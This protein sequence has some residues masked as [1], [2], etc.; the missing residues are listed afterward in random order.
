MCKNLIFLMSF[1]VVL[2]L[3]GGAWAYDPG[4]ILQCDAGDDPPTDDSPLQAGWT[5]IEDGWNVDVNSTGISVKLATG[6]PTAIE[7]RD[8]DDLSGAGHLADVEIDLFFANDR[9]TSPE[10]DFI[11][12]LTGLQNGAYRVRSYHNRWDEPPVPIT[13]VTVTGADS[14]LS[15]PSQWYWQEHLS[16]TIPL[17]VLFT[18]TGGQVEIR[19]KGPDFG[20]GG[21]GQVYFNGFTLEYFG[22]QNEAAYNPSPGDQAQ[23]LCPGDVASLSW[24]AGASASTHDIYFS[25]DIND[26]DPNESPTP[27]ESGWASTSWTPPALDLGTTY[28]WRVD[29]DT[30]STTWEGAIWR[31]TTNNGS[32]YDPYPGDGWRGV[33]TD[34]N[35]SWSPGCEADSH[36]VYFST[37]FN[38]VNN[39][40]P[41]GFKVNQTEL[42]YDP[43]ALTANTTYYW[44]I[45]EVRAGPNSPGEVW[46]FK[47]GT[48]VSGAIMYFKFDD[49]PLGTDLPS[50]V[51]DSTGNETF[52][53]FILD[54]NDPND[55][56]KYGVSNP[57]VNAA[58]GFS[59]EFSP[60]AGLYRNGQGSGD[61]LAL[62]GYQYTVEVWFNA[63]EVPGS[64]DDD[65]RGEGDKLIARGSSFWTLE[66]SRRAGLI[67][68]HTGSEG[69]RQSKFIYSGKNTVQEGEWYHAAAV[70]DITDSDQAMKLYLDGQLMATAARPQANP[71]DN[72][73]P[74]AIGF[75]RGDND[76]HFDGLIDEVRISNVALTVDE[77]LLVPGP[78]WARSPYPANN[79]RRVDPNVV[80]NWVPG[81]GAGTHDVYLGTSYD[82]IVGATTADT[83]LFL[84]NVGP[85]SIDPLGPDPLSFGTR[86][87][88]RVDE[89]N[90]GGPYTGVVWSFT[91]ASEVDDPNMI[92]WYMFDE[93]SGDEAFDASGH[94]YF[95]SV[96]GDEDGWDPN[97]GEGGC[98]IFDNDTAVVIPTEMLGNIV[99]EISIAVWL[100]DADKPGDDNWLFD[101][102]GGAP[103]SMSIAV[104]DEDGN[105]YWRAGTDGEDVLI[106]N[107]RQA[108][109][110]PGTLEDWHHWVFIKNENTPEISIYFDGELADTNGIVDS[111]LGYLRDLPSRV[112][113]YGDN[114]NDLVGKVDDFMVFD[115]AL[116]DDKVQELF[117]RGDVAL[118]WKPNPLNGQQ[119][120]YWDADLTWKPG[121]YT[122]STGGH[123]VYFGADWDD[124]NDMTDPCATLNLGNELYDPGQL[125]L[126]KTY[127]WR[128][129]EVNEPTTYKGK[130]WSFTVA[131][132]VV[133][134]DFESYDKGANLIYYTWY[135]KQ[136][137]PYGQRS[138]AILS[139]SYNPVHT[140]EQAMNY[141]YETDNT[142]IWDQDYAYA[143]ACLPLDEIGG[144][145]DWTSVDV[146]LVTIYF[147]GQAENDTN[148]TEQM[149]MAVHNASGNYAEVRYGDHP[150]EDM[151]DLKVE[152]WQRWDVPFVWFTDSNAAVSA[153]VDFSAISSVYLGFGDRFDPVPAGNGTVF[154]D[155]L[156]LSMPYC[157]PDY[158]PIGDLSGDCFVGVADIGE[159]GDQWLR[160]DINV[161]PVT[162]PPSSDPNLVGYWKLDGDATD[163]SDS[164]YH[165]TAQGAYQWVAGKDGQAID[166]SGGWVVVEDDGNTPKLRP[167]HYVSALAWVYVDGQA[168]EDTKVVIKG[169]DNEE[170]FGLEVDG[171][172]GA[173]FVFRDA[174]NPDEVLAAESGGSAVA[175]NEWIHIAGTYDQNDQLVYVNGEQAGS[176]TRGPIELFT[177]PNDGLGIGGRYG[178]TGGRFDGKIDDVRV[179]DRVVSRA[180]IAYIA[181]GADG[182]IP[183]ESAANLYSGENPE[184]I[185][186]RDFARLFEYWG[187][188]QL[189]PPE[190]AP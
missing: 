178:D 61:P 81:T 74:T 87:Y 151:N 29:E 155:N 92:L 115:Y 183:L 127:Y 56:V 77:F 41:A 91:V 174:N 73:A 42:S 144:F 63:S 123:K 141:Y 83:E 114:N 167:K 137:M 30:G 78:E 159:I 85:N 129:D 111:S 154:F 25:T 169:E 102:E 164:N 100:K 54:G 95:G 24:T 45:E 8:G 20:A 126:G 37:E 49:G 182:L 107:M 103:Y 171:E 136:A 1:A 97:D 152:E 184:V 46:S 185:N 119:N 34:V 160:H 172:D 28:Y 99:R 40:T 80:L 124:V 121:D 173:T 146:R 44:R 17:E 131:E 132:F 3:A 82:D 50:S 186:F 51:V 55:Y 52:T 10:N 69:D 147:Y 7:R 32:A 84:G 118:A 93:T 9:N 70:F 31:F 170:T 88:W 59:A 16:M 138:G 94:D 142:E 168:G 90:G 163:S 156:R 12:T 27:V 104:P 175:G 110:N 23:Q 43:G 60:E 38:D 47:T 11:L 6:D 133:L 125:E 62:D 68:V 21:T 66:V 188:E 36:N 128:V 53:K 76:D 187:T 26:V 72:N 86:Y 105:A 165:G 189:W 116:D 181:A 140:G 179:Y 120:V 180:E 19:Y 14:V 145:Q 48:G 139:L 117:R 153:N 58:G 4:T 79:Q 166:L 149:Y 22:S 101:C 122:Q 96:E 143:D 5:V 148:D 75:D 35:L 71:P 15:V 39:G 161:N 57:A 113:A 177:D 150:G 162:E 108:G 18:V 130:V 106:W 13:D 98:R 158:G 89:L 65:P 190:P 135:C 64:L 134:D 157:N 33:P 2:A 67:F 176:E 109:V 112:G